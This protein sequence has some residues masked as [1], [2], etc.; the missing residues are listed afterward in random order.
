MNGKNIAK[1]IIDTTCFERLSFIK[2]I[3]NN[4]NA[5]IGGEPSF[6]VEILD[7]LEGVIAKQS[8]DMTGHENPTK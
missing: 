3:C 7:G 8:L 6:A 4:E 1:Q 2:K 5:G